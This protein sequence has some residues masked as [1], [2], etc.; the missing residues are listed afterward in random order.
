MDSQR[1]IC[2]VGHNI[3]SDKGVYTIK[4]AS[5]DT[6]TTNISEVDKQRDVN[7]VTKKDDYSEDDL[8][9]QTSELPNQSVLKFSKDVWEDLKNNSYQRNEKEYLPPHW[10]DIIT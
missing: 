4:S 3:P 1:R 9:L 10:T 5:C 6:N 8:L 7:E 2:H